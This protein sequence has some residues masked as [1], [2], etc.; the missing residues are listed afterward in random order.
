MSNAP[1]PNCS[2]GA[3]QWPKDNIVVVLGSFQLE[4]CVK[5]CDYDHGVPERE[6]LPLREPSLNE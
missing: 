4:I 2:I 5:L 1:K 6:N 3:A